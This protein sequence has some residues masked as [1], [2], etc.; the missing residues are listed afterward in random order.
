M[1]SGGKEK[2]FDG[3][4]EESGGWDKKWRKIK[5]KCKVFFFFFFYRD[6]K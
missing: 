1:E 4:G 5:I 6:L 2:V 3:N